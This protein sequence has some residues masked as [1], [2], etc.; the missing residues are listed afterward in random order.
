MQSAQ[1]TNN[2]TLFWIGLGIV[3]ILVIVGFLWYVGVFSFSSTPAPPDCN[4][5][6][7]YVLDSTKTKCVCPF[8]QYDNGTKCI[9]CTGGKSFDQIAKV[10]IC[11]T[12]SQFDDN[13]ICVDYPPAPLGPPPTDFEHLQ[14]E[15][16]KIKNTS[17]DSNNNYVGFNNTK[18]IKVGKVLEYYKFIQKNNPGYDTQADWQ[19]AI[20]DQPDDMW[21]YF[22]GALAVS[23]PQA[24]TFLFQGAAKAPECILYSAEPWSATTA[25][26][27]MQGNGGYTEFGEIQFA[28]KTY[29]GSKFY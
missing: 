24:E 19:K 1:S 26:Q 27:E 17:H 10:C 21:R 5:A 28:D 13:G 12:N 16:M 8:G 25:T 11:P 23:N 20:A 3:V 15:A 18:K 29:T 14:T 9:T 22:C 2:S 6:S 4:T 7:G